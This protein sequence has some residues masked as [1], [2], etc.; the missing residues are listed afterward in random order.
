MPSNNGLVSGK[1]RQQAKTPVCTQRRS[2]QK[3]GVSDVGV[4]RVPLCPSTIPHMKGETL[5]HPSTP[6]IARAFASLVRAPFA[7]RKGLGSHLSV[8]PDGCWADD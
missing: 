6:G 4:I 1:M 8:A 3:S 7:L 2:L 5:L